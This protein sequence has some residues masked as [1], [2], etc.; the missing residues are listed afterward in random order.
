MKESVRIQGQLRAYLQWPLILS[1]F[2]L[3]ANLAVGFV[4]RWAG[5]VMSGFTLV[6]VIIAA[7]LFFYKKK[8]I[9][10]GLAEP[11]VFGDR[12]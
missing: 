11:C 5:M 1:A 10:D 6:Y 3:A 2:L 7:A 4:N 9:L 12:A 8:H